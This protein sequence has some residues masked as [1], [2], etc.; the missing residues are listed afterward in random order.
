MFHAILHLCRL[1]SVDELANVS[2]DAQPPSTSA[3]D[4]ASAALGA[5]PQLDSAAQMLDATFVDVLDA[6]QMLLR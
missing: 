3:L 5:L 4:A 2:H 6:H 1:S